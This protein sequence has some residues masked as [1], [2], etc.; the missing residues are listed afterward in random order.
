M[1]TRNLALEWARDNIRVVAV[2]PGKVDTLL[3]APVLRY[4]AQSGLDYNPTGR[5]G[6]PE[7]VADLIAFLVSAKAAFITGST[8]VIDGGELLCASTR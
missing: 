7:E 3:A 6:R 4:T 2:A 5:V 8:H 1:L